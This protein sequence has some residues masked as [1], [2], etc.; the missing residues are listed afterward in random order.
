MSETEAAPPAPTEQ[1]PAEA[2]PAAPEQQPEAPPAAEP[3][4]AEAPSSAPDAQPAAP[5]AADEPT[6]SSASEQPAAPAAAPEPEAPP[7]P[8]MEELPGESGA[9]ASSAEEDDLV[10]PLP[11]EVLALMKRTEEAQRAAEEEKERERLGSSTE[12]H[13]TEGELTEGEEEDEEMDPEVQAVL[14]GRATEDAERAQQ[15][16]SD[17][18]ARALEVVAKAGEASSNFMGS[19]ISALKQTAKPPPKPPRVPIERAPGWDRKPFLGG[20]R[21]KRNDTI[22]H[23]AQTQ[24]DK[25]PPSEEELRARKRA[26]SIENWGGN[27]QTLDNWSHRSRGIQT[28]REAAVQSVDRRGLFID[29]ST[30]VVVQPKPYI[31]ADQFEK[32]R[33]LAAVRIQC[34]VRRFV[35]RRI[36]RQLQQERQRREEEIQRLETEHI[37]STEE[38]HQGEL[39]RRMNPR[40]A[41]DIKLL[42]QELVEWKLSERAKIQNSAMTRDELREAERRLAEREIEMMGVIDGINVRVMGDRKTTVGTVCV[43]TNEIRRAQELGA[44]YKDVCADASNTEERLKVLTRVVDMVTPHP[45]ALTRDIVELCERERDLTAKNLLTHVAALRK[46]LSNLFLQFVEHPGFNPQAAM[47]SKA[48][49]SNTLPLN[50]RTQKAAPLSTLPQPPR[51]MVAAAHK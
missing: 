38:S 15:S 14:D 39:D 13:R 27:T 21:D 30:D 26:N 24:T 1:A 31:T 46:R 8:E 10:P 23:H 17:A 42:R 32:S 25:P 51:P 29:P 16:I 40:S 44:L 20:F 49:R 36:A 4:P 6:G 5:A 12:G 3:A 37:Q 2:A 7:K 43:E 22:Y 50:P 34:M 45:C 19:R 41:E 9:N 11:P 33:Y 28:L 48:L 35:A 47:F 18:V